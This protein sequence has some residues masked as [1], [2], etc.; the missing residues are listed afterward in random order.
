MIATLFQK[1]RQ[2][3]ASGHLT[4]ELLMLHDGA[5]IVRA[6]LAD[7]NGPIA[8]AMAVD[9]NLDQAEQQAQLKALAL[10]GFTDSRRS[11]TESPANQPPA[12]ALAAPAPQPE[13]TPAAPE[14]PIVATAS[15]SNE[16][17]PDEPASP[18][19]AP[20][21][22]LPAVHPL[23]DDE[24][25]T[26]NLDTSDEAGMPIDEIPEIEPPAE[27]LV[28]ALS[29]ELLANFDAAPTDLSDIIAQ[30]DVEMRRLGWTSQQGREYL[31]KTYQKRSRQQ[32][33]DEELLEFLLYLE[34]Q[35]MPAS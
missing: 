17:L 1:F 11:S 26:P 12:V 6:T 13:M 8:T 34:S 29:P 27:T 35:S 25:P 19:E 18:A 3:T 20:T 23:A 33:S 24:P 9:T 5:Y 32:L 28:E 15:T 10:L 21:T 31:E 30:T 4:T 16:R 7:A 14:H 22:A 2:A